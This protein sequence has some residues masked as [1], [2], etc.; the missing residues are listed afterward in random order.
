MLN[1]SR[2]F[3]ETD[4]RVVGSNSVQSSKSLATMNGHKIALTS[5]MSSVA[6]N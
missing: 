2:S 6:E 5:G 3:D 4:K 1:L